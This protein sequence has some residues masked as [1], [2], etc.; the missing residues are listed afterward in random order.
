MKKLQNCQETLMFL[1]DHIDIDTCWTGGGERCYSE[2]PEN[3]S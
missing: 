2:Y 1:K 3:D